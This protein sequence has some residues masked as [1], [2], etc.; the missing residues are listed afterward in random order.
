MRC[1]YYFTS[2]YSNESLQMQMPVTS[3]H[4]SRRLLKTLDVRE[5]R[6]LYSPIEFRFYQRYANHPNR[7]SGVQFLTHYDN[8]KRFYIMKDFIDYL[9]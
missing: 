3:L 8:H 2:S 5:Y 1:R 6:P 9:H 4:T 7:A